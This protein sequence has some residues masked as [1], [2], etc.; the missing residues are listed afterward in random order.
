LM[1]VAKKRSAQTVQ[2]TLEVRGR[3]TAVADMKVA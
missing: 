1:V 3:L 2:R